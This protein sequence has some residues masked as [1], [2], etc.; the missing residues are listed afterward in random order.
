MWTEILAVVIVALA[1]L[2]CYVAHEKSLLHGHLRLPKFLLVSN[3]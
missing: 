3:R 2:V 1:N